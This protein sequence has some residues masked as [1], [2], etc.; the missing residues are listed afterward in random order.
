MTKINQ[1]IRN[2]EADLQCL[3]ACAEKGF[4]IQD[5]IKM[6]KSTL[7]TLWSIYENEDHEQ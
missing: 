3:E 2:I 5:Y 7:K 1:S 6:Q 4:T